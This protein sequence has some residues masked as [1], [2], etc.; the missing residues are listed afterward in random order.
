MASDRPGTFLEATIGESAYANYEVD[1]NTVGFWHMEEN[2]VVPKSCYSY[3]L[4]GYNT[5]GIYWIDP[6]GTGR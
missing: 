2:A 5:T 3:L 1:A 6:D 4:N